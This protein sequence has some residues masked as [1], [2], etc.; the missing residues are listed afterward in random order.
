MVKK[1]NNKLNYKSRSPVSL[2]KKLTDCKY[3]AIWQHSKT[4]SPLNMSNQEIDGGAVTGDDKIFYQTRW[5]KVVST[6]DVSIQ[7]TC[8]CSNINQ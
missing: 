8:I 7:H 1:K 6:D 4:R 3:N 5:N 2:S